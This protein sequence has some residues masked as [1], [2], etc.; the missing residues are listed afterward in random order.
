MTCTCETGRGLIGRRRNSAC[1]VHGDGVLNESFVECDTCQA[2]P[3][4]NPIFCE[5]CRHNRAALAILRQRTAVATG[6]AQDLALERDSLLV[7]LGALRGKE[8]PLL[9]CVDCKNT[10]SCAGAMARQFNHGRCLHCGGYFKVVR[11]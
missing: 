8:P 6:Q 5:G 1:P 11:A 3:G 9:Q 7:E 4:D 2:K 10:E